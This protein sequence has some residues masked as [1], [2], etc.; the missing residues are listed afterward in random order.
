MPI[1]LGPAYVKALTF[2]HSYD[3]PEMQCLKG[4]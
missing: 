4:L 1:A 2:Q 3:Q